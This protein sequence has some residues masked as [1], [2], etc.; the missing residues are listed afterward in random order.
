M[1]AYVKQT[2]DISENISE[3]GTRKQ[4]LE[5]KIHNLFGMMIGC[6]QQIATIVS[7]IEEK[8]IT[9]EKNRSTSEV[10]I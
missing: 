4:L 1:S 5:E 6:Q 3:N 8:K 2:A 9:L 7:L 10:A